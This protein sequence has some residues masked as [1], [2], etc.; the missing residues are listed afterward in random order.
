MQNATIEVRGAREHNLR[1]VSITLP[2][3]QLIVFTGVSGSGKSSMAFDT[4]YAEGQRRYL[5]S[6]SSYARQFIGQLPKPNVDYIGGLSPAISISQKSTSSNPRST[7][8]T[9]TEIYDFLR[10]LYARVGTGFCSK[11]QIPIASQT[12]DQI[13]AQLQALSEADEYLILAPIVRG[14][15]GEHRELFESLQ[16]QGYARARV[17]G[18]VCRLSEAPALNRQQKHDIE[19]VVSRFEPSQTPRS[20]IADSVNEAL[21]LGENS[22][23]VI[24]WQD[25]S[26]GQDL[27]EDEEPPKRGRRRKKPSTDLVIS[28]EYA[29]PQCGLST[30]PP[31]PQLLSFNSPNGMCHV[32]EG[33]GRQFTFAPELIIPDPSKSL[34][35]GAIE[36]IGGWNDIGRWQ[37]HQLMSVS[38]SIEKE[39]GLQPGESLTLPWQDL[40]AEVRHEWLNGTG[41]RHITYTWRGGSRPMKYGGT[42]DGIVPTLMEQYRGA[43]STSARKRFEKYMQKRECGS[44]GGT[45]LNLQARQ[46][47]MRSS[48]QLPGVGEWLNLPALCS[49]PIDQCLQFIE[50]LELNEIELRIASEALREVRSRLTFLLN[51]GLEYLCL[52]RSAPS[53]SGGEAQR[54][55]L[56]SQIGSG[57]VGV[58][59]VLDEPSIGLHPRDNDRLI[60]S[61]KALR[62]QGNSLLVVEH[63]EDTMRAADLILDFGPGPGVRGGEIVTCGDLS[64]LAAAK[65]SSTGKF[66]AGRETIPVPEQRRVG[67]GNCLRVVGAT[68]NNLKDVDV[69][70]PLGK[71]VCVTGVS[72]SGKSSL[73]NDIV[74]P[75]LRRELHAAEDVP[76]THQS[77]QGIEHLDKVIAID[78]SPIGRTPRS[79]PATYVKVFDEIRSLFVGLPEAKRRGYQPGRFSFNVAGGRC[80]ACEG[81]GSNRLEMDFLADL[82]VTCPVCDG[83]RYNHETL[84][85]KFK[86][87]SISDV[88][89]MDIQQALELFENVPKIAEKLQTLHDVGLDYIKLGQPSPTLSGG[90]AQRIKLAKELSR[91]DTGRTL[92]L[93]DEP[94][95]GLHFHDIRLLLQVLQDL[96]DKGNTVLVIEHNLDV[97]KAA[98]WLIDVGPEGGQEG[99]NIVFTGTP[100]EI[101]HVPESHTG[102]SLAK[103]LSAPPI[104]PSKKKRAKTTTTKGNSKNSPRFQSPTLTVQGAIEHNLKDLSIEIPHHTLSVFCGPSGSGKSSLAMDTIYAEGQRRYVESLSSYARQFVGQMPKPKVE[105]IE[106][107][108]PS[109]AIEQKSV[110]HNPRSTVGTVTEIYDYLRVLMARLGEPHCPNCDVPVTNQTADDIATHLLSR[111][112][113]TRLI[114]TAPLRWQPSHDPDN[115]W[116]DLR[117]SGLVRVRVNGR[118]HSLNEPPQLSST[119]SYDL[120]AVVDRITISEKNRSRISESVELALSLGNGTLLTLEP[121]DDIDEIHWSVTRHSQHLACR[122]CGYSLE[123]LTPHSF[124]FNSPLGWCP[125]C[126][127]LG[128]QTGTSPALL[129]DS[130]L[131]LQE[132]AIRLWP[133]LDEH[134]K[135]ELPMTEL[136]GPMLQTFCK[137]VGIPMDVPV[138]KLTGGQRRSILHGTGDRWYSITTTKDVEFEFQ[139]KGLFPALEHA[140]RLSPSLRNKLNPFVA[141]VACSACDGSR[142][143]PESAAAKFRGLTVGD[144]TQGTLKWL[145]EQ[146]SGWK[147]SKREQQIAG[148]LVRELLARTSFLLDVGL[149]YLSLSRP[150]NTLSGG[151]SQRIRL[152]SQLGSG[153]CGVLYVLDEP[154]IGLHPRDNTRLIS[155]LQKL[156]DLG[157]TLVVVE[158]DREVIEA[159]DLLCDFGPGAGRYG[160]ELVGQGSP[161]QVARLKS[162]VTGPYLSDKQKI[163]VPHVRRAVDHGCISLRGARAHN[164]HNVSVDFPLGKM[165]VVTGPSGSGKSTLVNEVLYPAMLKK[166]S[167]QSTKKSTFDSIEGIKLIDKVIR[168]DQSPLGSNPSSTP[169]TYTGVFDLIRQLYSQL[170]ASRALGYTPRQFSF[171]VPGGRCEKCEGNG[172][173]R[174]E[175]HFLPDVWVQCDSCH[176]RRFT[177]DTLSVDYHGFSIHDVLEMQIGQALEVFDNIPKIRRILQTLVDV[178]LDYISLGQSAPTL[179]GGEAQRVKLAAE[180]ARPDTGKTF[181]LLDEPTTGLHFTDITKLLEVLHRL[182]DIGNTVTVIEHNL[183]VIKAADWVIDLG[184]E[185]GHEGG[186]L[187]FAGTPEDLVAYAR[188]TQ[189]RNSKGDKPGGQGLRSHTGEALIPLMQTAEYQER[190]VYDPDTLHEAQEG[191]LDLDQ[192]GRDTLLPWQTDGRKWHTRDSLDRAGNPI[193]WDRQI[194]TRIIDF[195]E[196]IDGF[197]PTNWENRS[198]VEVTGP[199]KSRGWFLHA[200]TA[201]TWLL[202]LKFRVP[203]RSFTKSQLLSI[204]ELPTLNQL[205]EVQM[206]GNEPRTKARASGQWMELE[207]R[208]HTLAEIDNNKFWNW[209]RDASFAFLGK[210][211]TPKK[212]SPDSKADPKSHMPWK[213]MKQR[214]HSMRKG[215]PPGKDIVWPAETLSV[216]IQAVHQSA[217]G[218]RWRWDDQN[219]A[220]YTLPGQKEPWIIL[221]TK[222]P[223]GLI[224]VLNGPK[225]YKPGSWQDT[226]PMKVQITSLGNEE[227]QIQIAFTELQQP[228]D[229]AVRKLLSTHMKF[230]DQVAVGK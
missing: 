72:G 115:L 29:C 96:V 2:R 36:L 206:Y 67:S 69:E 219:T 177:E 182:V 190:E 197:S 8:G 179:S 230:V 68:H 17:D 98:D 124:S 202:K 6:L 203:R 79:N 82:W 32:C 94:T 122:T 132:G 52:S 109:V 217:G 125:D 61:L 162:S 19:V 183:D 88:L 45:R 138:E 62:D 81:N 25:E 21:K 228:R 27:P 60:D 9:V 192:I 24:P 176:G 89:D 50:G 171:N 226:L 172:Q 39:H 13:V 101:V 11:C 107:L 181:Y 129:L 223:E 170:P 20:K 211:V 53:L 134:S 130:H 225:G 66:L 135:S 207:I 71:F 75:V 73:I 173:I 133:A 126:E 191:D 51:V 28:S 208:P 210:T 154:T 113:G 185:A 64:D 106:G 152:S 143:R 114:I 5:E 1:N 189:P 156:R 83:R 56:A 160:G 80:E 139:W 128:T 147:L 127:G 195:L 54:I 41:D 57:L 47:K 102:R 216:L 149:D 186:Q 65:H 229:P 44:C 4:L 221:H 163:P 95:T 97:I 199:V 93:L 55:R 40:P 214:W 136:A 157:N 70:L 200:I 145:H 166:L 184:P 86:D 23:I 33:L 16:R 87:R 15:K 12:R 204:V 213:V 194:L 116:Q 174:I 201:E 159:S 22:L 146:I 178:G 131:S 155:A 212:E 220:R 123:P 76:G 137:A 77:L 119:L 104:Q 7:V 205:E 58:L 74:V 209:L 224:A 18:Q 85:V 218:G 167:K 188:K 43:K 30:M 42:F 103:H 227:E 175:M 168:V 90:E 37:R 140:S 193:R 198:I 35:Q 151:E 118:T 120:E 14:Q 158:H 187:V 31:T 144:Y 63:D 164:L 10:V 169:A 108:A 148:E 46:L 215:F 38:Q 49:L 112:E 34:R 92:Y 84:Q 59:Y 222:R 105:R 165:N 141:E 153:L 150:A 111:E 180:L 117:T 110:A 99:G 121:R 48:A 91:R 100:D 161:K 26:A 142:L 78:Q 3:N 196:N